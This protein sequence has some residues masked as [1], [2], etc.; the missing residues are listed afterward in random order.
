MRVTL[1][2]SFDI[3]PEE[4]QVTLFKDDHNHKLL[5]PEKVRFLSAYRNIDKETEEQIFLFKKVGLSIRQ[6]MRII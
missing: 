2:R 4:W 5:S 6:I 3:F 1:K